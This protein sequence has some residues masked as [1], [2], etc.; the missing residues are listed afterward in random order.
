VSNVTVVCHCGGLSGFD[1]VVGPLGD[2][3]GAGNDV[4]ASG[5]EAAT[6]SNRLA[7][8]EVFFGRTISSAVEA[9]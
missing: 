1:F 5:T 2:H 4:G 3:S 6:W 9:V 8:P 7:A